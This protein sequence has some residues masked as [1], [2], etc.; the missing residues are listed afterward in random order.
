MDNQAEIV[1]VAE[2]IGITNDYR[3]TQQITGIV[4]AGGIIFTAIDAVLSSVQ[5]NFSSVI[6]QS[7][8]LM[9]LFTAIFYLIPK[10][11]M[12]KWLAFLPDL[13]Y[14]SGFLVLMV[15]LG[16]NKG[17]VIIILL[18]LLV[19][20]SA[21]T[22]PNWQFILAVFE[23]LT[24]II[25]YYSIT[26]GLDQT[27]SFTSIMFQILGIIALI[28]I[29]RIFAQETIVLRGE[30]KHLTEVGFQLETQRNEIL[31]L[32]NN[33]SQG[34]ISVD[35]KQRIMIANTAAMTILGG[36]NKDKKIT[37]IGKDLDDVM[38]VASNE[39]KI[40]LAAEVFENG[41]QTHY[42]DL[43]L[44]A[45]GGMY[46]ISVNTTPIIDSAT[47]HIIG[48]IVSFNDIT[49]EKSLDE[50]QAEFNSIAS[51]ELRTPLA[52]IEGFTYNLLSD[53]RLKY[54]EKT[55][56]YISKIDVAVNSLIKLTNDIL[57]VTKSDN[58]QIK[59]VFEKI[60]I[61]KLVTEIAEQFKP[62]AITKNLDFKLDIARNLPVMLT[63]EG[64]FKE[65]LSNLIENAIKFT[66]EGSIKIEASENEKG[67]I[68]I[69]VTDTG[70]GIRDVD[71]K[72]IFNRFYRVND[73][74]TQKAGG[75]GLGLYISRTFIK[76]MGG[77][78]G[79]DS[80]RGKGSVFWFKLPVAFNREMVKDKSDEQLE[81]FI[82]GI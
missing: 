69:K 4:A 72:R 47:K 58:D 81:D 37:I 44:V 82:V 28:S 57:T 49:A 9:A 77:E 34:L 50:Q 66:D 76:A 63:D 31:T 30:Q 18:L 27:M 59:V 55:R 71:Q 65:V 61:K 12:T 2:E 23:T 33:L 68:T 45:P 20:I 60:D 22:K 52:V 15:S 16:G 51:H 7:L 8:G 46:R 6:W 53:S 36:S 56:E 40:S 54:D 78:I 74:R 21:F 70:E 43:K 48:A 32:I 42:E 35:K 38:P 75:T 41:E 64:K 39:S 17:E 13:I 80:V 1:P 25:L 19:A 24:V 5:P 26:G 79:V 67:F 10:I 3:T 11:Y 29:L 73:F 14:T 62:K